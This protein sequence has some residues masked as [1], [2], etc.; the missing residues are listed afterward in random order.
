MSSNL[1]K[2]IDDLVATKTF[3][4]DALEGIKKIKDELA[5]TLAMTERLTQGIDAA[6]KEIAELKACQAR[7]ADTIAA[8]NLKLK[9][10]QETVEQGEAAIW[11]KKISDATAEAYK[12][13]LYVVF[14]PSSVREVIQRNHAVVVPSG[15]SSYIQSVSHQDIITREDV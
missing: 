11:Q 1:L 5:V 13:A 9:D 14:K 15:N 2:Q 4:L 6:R 12:D 10:G 8:L 7:D 3:N